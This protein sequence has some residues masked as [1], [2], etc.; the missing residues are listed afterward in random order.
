MCRLRGDKL[1][2]HAHLSLG[3]NQTLNT[4]KHLTCYQTLARVLICQNKT[5]NYTQLR[6]G[7]NRSWLVCGLEDEPKSFSLDSLCYVFCNL[8]QIISFLYIKSTLVELKYII[9][10]PLLFFSF[11]LFLFTITSTYILENLF[12]IKQKYLVTE[13]PQYSLK[14]TVFT[15]C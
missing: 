8:T 10:L 9:F 15:E 11:S 5:V 3:T 13:T 2:N 7:F 1:S 14:Q 12:D 4:G 6:W